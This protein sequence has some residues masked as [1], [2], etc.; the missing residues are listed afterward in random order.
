[1]DHLRKRLVHLVLHAV[2]GP[3]GLHHAGTPLIAQPGGFQLRFHIVAQQHVD[4]VHHVRR[5]PGVLP[6]QCAP[7]ALRRAGGGE[8]R[9][10]ERA[11]AVFGVQ[12]G[13]A[14]GQT[15][16]VE[17]AQSIAWC[18]KQAHQRVGIGVV[19][20]HLEQGQHILDFRSVEH[21]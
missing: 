6:H 10:H 16:E 4:Q 1:M 21:G 14:S 7:F 3:H 13:G 5:I 2:H 19:A 9:L 11:E 20:H 18:G 17:G 15:L 8:P 12:I